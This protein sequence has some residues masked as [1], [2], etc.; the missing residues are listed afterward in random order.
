MTRCAV[1]DTL[2]RNV[3]RFSGLCCRKQ[4]KTFGHAVGAYARLKTIFSLSYA[5]MVHPISFMCNNLILNIFS[6]RN[7]PQI[8]QP[9]VVWVSVNV[10]NVVFRPFAMHVKP[11]QS[12]RPIELAVNTNNTVTK[13]IYASCN[14]T[15]QYA[16]ISFDAPAQNAACGVTSKQI[17]KAFMSKHMCSPMVLSC[18]SRHAMSMVKAP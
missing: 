7:V 18:S 10:V 4:T 1:L 16:S 13:I 6:G 17:L 14:T 12:V 15:H 3:S 11:N 2:G 9:I 5:K 8:I